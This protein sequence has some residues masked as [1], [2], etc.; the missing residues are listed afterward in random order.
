MYVVGRGHG[1]YQAVEMYCPLPDCP[2]ERVAIQFRGS[3]RR[4]VP[5]VVMM[6]APSGDVELRADSDDDRARLEQLWA[7]D[8]LRHPDYTARLKGRYTLIRQVRERLELPDG[9]RPWL[10]GRAEA[11]RSL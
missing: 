3:R 7:A 2:C 6:A 1:R 4:R 5:G 11:G 10:G 8:R 9:T